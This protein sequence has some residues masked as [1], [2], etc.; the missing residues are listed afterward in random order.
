MKNYRTIF[1]LMLVLAGS[2]GN[3]QSDLDNLNK[4]WSYRDRF[5]KNFLHAG[6]G[7]GESLPISSRRIG[8]PSGSIETFDQTA[9]SFYWQDGTIYL[10][11]YMQVLATEYRL[12]S[13]ANE[14]CDQT[15]NEI[16]YCLMTLNRLDLKSENYL[17]QDQNSQ[18]SEDLNGFFLRDDVSYDAGQELSGFCEDDYSVVFNRECNF[19]RSNSDFFS[20]ADWWNSE[21]DIEYNGANG[22][23][24]DQLITILS[25]LLFIDELVDPV[26]VQP[27]E[28][29]PPLNLIDET[30]A[31]TQRIIHYLN[32]HEWRY[33]RV[34]GQEG[35]E[36]N[37]ADNQGWIC[38]GNN[39][40]F[41]SYPI[42]EIASR[43]LELPAT[44]M[45]N[46]FIDHIQDVAE[47][48]VCNG[49]D[50]ITNLPPFISQWQSEHCNDGNAESLEVEV[51]ISQYSK[52][53]EYME[54][55]QIQYTS[56][57]ADIGN[58]SVGV[59]ANLCVPQFTIFPPSVEIQC[60]D[61]FNIEIPLTALAK[62]F[63]DDNIH[64][65]YEAAT[66]SNIWNGFYVNNLSQESGL[67]HMPLMHAVLNNQR[68]PYSFQ[69]KSSFKTEY[70]DTSPCGGPY[71]HPY[72]LQSNSGPIWASNNKLFHFNNMEEGPINGN[73]D[74]E[75][76]F[77]G[78][79]S[80]IDWMLY[81][82]LYH[83][84]WADELPD[85]KRKPSCECVVEVIESATETG[86]IEVERKFPDYKAKGIPIES[87]LA[88]SL[89]VSTTTGILDVKNDLIICRSNPDIPTVLTIKDGAKLNIYEGN[90][91]T[92]RAGN[93]IIIEDGGELV[94]GIPYDECCNGDATLILEENAELHVLNAQFTNYYGLKFELKP[95]AKFIVDDGVVM[96]TSQCEGSTIH[97]HGGQW[98][99]T[100]STLAK[101]LNGEV[102]PM[103]LD[104]GSTI[105]FTYCDVFP[106]NTQFN[107]SENTTLTLDHCEGIIAHGGISLDHNSII[108]LQYTDLTL[109][110][111]DLTFDYGSTLFQYESTLNCIN[112][113]AVE[114]GLVFPD[115]QEPCHYYYTS[116]VVTLDGDGTNIKF[117]NAQLHIPANTT[118]QP[119]HPNGPSGY[120]EF[121]GADDHELFT[122]TNSVFKIVGDGPND[123]M[124]KMN[125]YADLWNANFGMGTIILQ[126]CKVDL[127]DHGRLWTDMKF[128]ASNVR[129]EDSQTGNNGN[130]GGNIQIWNTNLCTLF[131]CDFSNVR[132]LTF[133]TKS[134]D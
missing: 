74:P 104:F 23:S 114:F 107:I 9:S 134:N 62:P 80:G 11:H 89:E 81:Y 16:Y 18:G 127:T 131:N 12:L 52:L 5:V 30:E 116:G 6:S 69:S 43:I 102:I 90:T 56:S 132:L 58:Y 32:E 123:V 66:C 94:G 72:D 110:S 55:Y 28:N 27:T 121:R 95:G 49:L 106:L 75:S 77:R 51:N 61:L 63:D 115:W 54:L 39:C 10:G 8:F 40:R 50:G 100:N 65:V 85:Y 125:G 14:N 76:P 108:D 120:I 97:C 82:N 126:N 84:L 1:L 88:H 59:D 128:Q 42:A 47:E 113:S 31:I 91:L 68:N 129:F 35:C 67:F 119:I 79:F 112:N 83:L 53:W 98:L 103:N 124:L 73:G 45:G 4:Y 87:F 33:H 17:S 41:F 93:K 2:K 71:A 24:L 101:E 46:E 15:L 105:T 64:M 7:E 92:V 29:D 99:M 118:F 57:W 34:N 3:A 117:D 21:T 96:Y 48:D 38:S 111:S 36:N 25:G 26:V 122:G 60:S 44:E 133:N 78:E 22:T 86:L 19:Q 13:D 130:E 70:I 109:N 37:Q 20:A